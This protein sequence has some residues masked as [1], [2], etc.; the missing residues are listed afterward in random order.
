VLHRVPYLVGWA[1][2]VL[3][4]KGRVL[5]MALGLMLE[6]ATL[7]LKDAGNHDLWL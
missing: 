7:G 5:G 4:A 3:R 2:E 1:I 6:L